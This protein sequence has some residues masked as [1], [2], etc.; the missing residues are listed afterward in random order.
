[1]TADRE[2]YRDC[3]TE[4]DLSAASECKNN[5]VFGPG[6]K[7]LLGPLYCLGAGSGLAVGELAGVSPGTG[8]MLGLDTI[9]SSLSVYLKQ[10][11]GFRAISLIKNVETNITSE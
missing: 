11:S 4:W 1:M 2:E 6:R 5:L 8:G 9:T 10:H 7:G 3:F